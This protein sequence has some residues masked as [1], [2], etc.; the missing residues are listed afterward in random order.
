MRAAGKWSKL[1][2][3]CGAVVM[4]AATETT[5]Q[6]A[7]PG[8]PVAGKQVRFPTG[9]W[10]ALPQVGPDGR[11]RQCVLI[12][13]RSR[14]GRGGAIATKLSLTIGRGAGL[15]IAIRDGEVPSEQVLDDQAEILLDGGPS[16]PTVGFTVGTDSLAVHPGDAAGVL[17][18]L[19]KAGT[20]TLRSAGAGIDT[21]PI[22]LELPREALGWLKRCGQTFDIAI[23]RPSDPAA[24]ALPSP[25]PRSPKVSSAQ[26]TAAGPAGIEDKQKISGWDASELRGADGA[27]AVCM[28]R[29]HYATGSEPGA[30][31]LATFLVMS[32]TK[33]VMMMLK[34]SSLNL[35]SGQAI[36]A[37]LSIDGK[38]FSEFSARVLGPDEIGLFPRDGAALAL[39]LEAGDRFDFKAPMLGMEGPIQGGVVPWLRACARRH[40]FAIE[41]QGKPD[42]R[43]LY[44]AGFD[45]RVAGDYDAAI[46]LLSDALATGKL[47][48]DDRSTSYNNRGMAFAAKGQ[49]DKAVA[50]YTMA[51]KIAPAYG[52]AYLNRGNVYLNQGNLDAA[53]A[54]Y[55]LAIKISPEYELAYNSRGAAYY[56]KGELDAALADLDTAIRLKPDYG[57][58]YWNRARVYNQKGDYPKALADFGA[59]IRIKPKEPAIYVD[60]GDLRSAHHDN[61]GAIAD[62]TA[63]IELDPNVAPV[64]N[65]RGNS[66]FAIGEVDKAIADFDRAIRLA[67]TFP[68]PVISRGRIALFHGGRSA[69]AAA[70]LASGVRLAPA[71]IYAAIWLHIARS[72][73]NTP[74]HEE[75]AA[76]AARLGPGSWPRPV[77]DLFL[78]TATPDALRRAASNAKDDSTRQEQ[79]CEA[80]FYLGMFNLERKARDDARKLIAAAAESCPADM[81][82]KPAAKAELARLSQ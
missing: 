67:P 80:D 8:K 1:A 52:P 62:Y 20:L 50:D 47:N 24:P 34:D 44:K 42:A 31:R 74:D 70:D 23:D 60:R 6:A 43:A 37:T 28:I 29:R 46:R 81:L 65:N 54:D 69:A 79:L 32:R 51:I 40:G 36:E 49:D 75:L 77:L 2:M 17:L 72:R 55:S 21:G 76:N 16:F 41:P 5:S 66:Y 14:A 18:A 68:D 48:D 35:P 11:V 56:R 10:S 57:N 58:A 59:A 9:Y 4:L 30:R 22:T 38:Q 15:A 26:P 45:A 19:E 82:E 25:R 73:S 53:I 13:M 12:A 63:A 78:G 27:V 64:Y 71:D 39:A 3:A 61:A 7:D 33:G